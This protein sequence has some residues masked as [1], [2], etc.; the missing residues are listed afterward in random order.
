MSEVLIR[1]AVAT[2]IQSI[3]A[4]D[5]STTSD[6]VW[7]FDL[8]EGGDQIGA[9]FREIRL[10]RSITVHYP[11]TRD[12]LVDNWNRHSKMIVSVLDNKVIGY[13]RITGCI[14]PETSWITDLVVLP[15]FRRRGIGMTLIQAAQSWAFEQQSLRVVIEMSAKNHPAISLVKKLGY[16]FCGYNDNYYAT[17]DVAIF[18]G[19]II[20]K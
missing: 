4:M 17:K 18:F 9:T 11:K 19:K 14:N 5:H 20:R 16:E 12:T 13:V 10:P 8:Q 7:Q 15:E 6:Y 1:N 2:D 3:V